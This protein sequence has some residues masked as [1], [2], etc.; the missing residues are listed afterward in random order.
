MLFTFVPNRY[1]RQCTLSEV[2]F[3][4]N[5]VLS[6]LFFSIIGVTFEAS[7][8]CNRR[9]ERLCRGLVECLILVSFRNAIVSAV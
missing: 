1:V 6:F 4:A 2:F 5:S 9:F 3:F 8:T 7:Y